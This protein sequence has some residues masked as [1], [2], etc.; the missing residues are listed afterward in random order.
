MKHG[1]SAKARFI[2]ELSAF[3][4]V[5]AMF[6]ANVAVKVQKQPQMEPYSYNEND[7]PRTVAHQT[8]AVSEWAEGFGPPEDAETAASADRTPTEPAPMPPAQS[9]SGSAVR[10]EP[11][12]QNPSPEYTNA[13]L[14]SSMSVTVVRRPEEPLDINSATLA[15]LME[16]DGIGETRGRAII[17]YREE[18]GAFSSVDELLNVRGIGEKTLEK[19]RAHIT[20]G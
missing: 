1:L 7:P 5:L 10:T 19:L 4:A 11:H 6:I 9:E 18:H 15:E 17:A 16:L 3:I 12:P 8:H 20:V 13:Q 14:Q 2:L